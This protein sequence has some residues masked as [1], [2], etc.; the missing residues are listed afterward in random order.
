MCIQNESINNDSV[1]ISGMSETDT[2]RVDRNVETVSEI[3]G[4]ETEMAI[5][6]QTR[7]T[8][9]PLNDACFSSSKQMKK[10]EREAEQELLKSS[11]DCM[12]RANES[13]MSSCNTGSVC[14][15]S[16]DDDISAFGSYIK[17]EMHKMRKSGMERGISLAK[18]RIQ[19]VMF[20]VQ[21]EANSSLSQQQSST[22]FCQQG[23][24]LAQK[25]RPQQQMQIQQQYWASPGQSS[26]M[27]T[28]PS[29]YGNITQSPHA[30]QEGRWYQ[31]LGS[32]GPYHA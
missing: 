9:R 13:L 17:Q 8:K 6:V 18:L 22:G 27:R 7:S 2:D 28:F 12:K 11:I 10:R 5:E 21:N 16:V 3:D 30:S 1:S 19:Q 32:L 31:E 14:N 20:E 23:Q 29:E 4:G 25:H 15:G 26:M 24:Y